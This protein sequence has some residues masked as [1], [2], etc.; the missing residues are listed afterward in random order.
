MGYT[1]GMKDLLFILG[2]CVVAAVI[3]AYLY[4]YTPQSLQTSSATPV[5]T[6]TSTQD[7]PG[8]PAPVPSVTFTTIDIGTHAV[9][10][11]ARKNYV[12]GDAQGLTKLW[13]L[14]FGETGSTT[15]KIDFGTTEVIGVFAGTKPTGG[16]AIEVSKVVDGIDARTIYVNIVKPGANCVTTES[17]TSPFAII[18]LPVSTLPLAHQDTTSVRDCN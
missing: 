9:N 17:V 4:F 12:A 8:E 15:P 18:T 2:I 6:T 7:T 1:H 3:G 11:T 16:Y 5:E 13:S 10:V 14:A